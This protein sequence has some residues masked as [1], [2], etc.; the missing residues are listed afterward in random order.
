MIAAV[1]TIREL[2]E[3]DGVAHMWRIGARLMSG[4]SSIGAEMGV[5]LEMAGLP[6]IPILRFT[7]PDEVRREAV[8]KTFFTETTR[9][10]VL[11]HPGHCWFLSLAHTDADVDR[12]LEVSRASLKAARGVSVHGGT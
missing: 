7:D 12:T 4:L 10:G 9:R 8:R 5:P 2:K 1:E 3:K 6:P 11:F